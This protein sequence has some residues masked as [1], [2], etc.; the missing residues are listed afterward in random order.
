[1][2]KISIH[3]TKRMVWSIVHV[4][5]HHCLNWMYSYYRSFNFCLMFSIWVYDVIGWNS[6]STSV[7]AKTEYHQ[8][9]KHEDLSQLH[10]VFW[11]TY[12][13]HQWEKSCYIFCN[14]KPTIWLYSG[15]LVQLGATS[16]S[17]TLSC[18]PLPARA[19][20][21]LAPNFFRYICVL[22]TGHGGFIEHVLVYRMDTCPGYPPPHHCCIQGKEALG[23]M[24]QRW[25]VLRIT[26]RT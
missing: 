19:W 1:M 26:L 12:P 3:F 15:Q 22:P 2:L 10:F 20:L 14:G 6:V 4:L 8:L 7:I 5:Q 13:Q 11:W 24:M 17:K 23:R 9:P 21:Q 16:A 18:Q 25:P